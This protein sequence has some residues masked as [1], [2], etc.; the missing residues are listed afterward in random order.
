MKRSIKRIISFALVMT[1]LL[2]TMITVSAEGTIATEDVSFEDELMPL[3]ADPCAS[4]NAAGFSGV[5][6]VYFY[7]GL[8]EINLRYNVRTIIPGEPN[9]TS[10]SYVECVDEM[11]EIADEYIH[12]DD[13]E[14]DDNVNNEICKAIW[15]E[16]RADEIWD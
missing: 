12:R 9:D 13:D 3:V 4:N 10:D 8:N 6:F 2:S 11:A 15:Y 7:N 14:T 1:M 16:M 5:A